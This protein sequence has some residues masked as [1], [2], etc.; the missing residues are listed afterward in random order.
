MEKQ[1]GAPLSIG[2]TGGIGCGKSTVADMFAALGATVVDTDAIAHRLTAPHGAAMPA[3]A[4]E[5]GP[6]FVT[7]EGALDRVRMR[8]LVFSD[9]AAR[10]RLEAI[11]HPLIRHAADLAAACGHGP[12]VIFAVPLLIESGSWRARVARIL[13]VDCPES[14]QISRVMARNGLP[15]A[16]VKAIM[17]T[18]VSRAAR[19]AAADDIITN[20]DGIEA[21]RPQIERLHRFYLAF[22]ERMVAIPI[23]RL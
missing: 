17:A 3:I 5:F 23:E 2:L 8:D 9:P 14:M 4:A 1:H 20:D 10:L 18:Q 19:L 22:S 6:G 16:Q 7:P 12:Y 21:L 15:E 11:L 13:V